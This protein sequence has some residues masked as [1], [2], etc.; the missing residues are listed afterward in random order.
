MKWTFTD[1]RIRLYLISLIILL[2]GLSGAVLV[3]IHAENA[4]DS[5]LLNEFEYSKRYQH[6]L[7]L[8]G[9]KAN[10]IASEIT[11]WFKGLW[12]G[13]NLAYSIACIAVLI[14]CGFF[15]AARHIASEDRYDGGNGTGKQT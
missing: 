1:Q 8:Y 9:G 12:H 13:K 2:V 7:E 5:A 14:S 3:Y 4:S 10:V 15:I 11:N 6:D